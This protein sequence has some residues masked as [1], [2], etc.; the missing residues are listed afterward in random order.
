MS[1][2][3][4]D[5]NTDA[6]VDFTNKLEK[7]HKSAMPVAIRTALNS[8][9][10]DVKQNTMP[11]EAKSNFVNRS[12]NFFKANSKVEQA[13]GF[14]VNTMK[15]TVGFVD[16]NLVGK[17]NYAVK[18]LEQQEQG[19]KIS[20]KAFIPTKNA[21]GGYANKM[22]KAMNRLSSIKNIV[23]A[24]RAKGVNK[25]QRFIKSAVHAGK[26]G[27][28]LAEKN[29]NMILWRVNSL[30][31]TSKGAFKLTALYSYKKK[32]GVKVSK[33]QFMRTASLESGGKIDQYFRDSA[34]KQF[35]KL[36]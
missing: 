5:I 3:V 14:N 8:A 20:N 31:R 1:A 33:T 34:Q 12:K 29:G 17:S 10:F 32:R 30:K 13:Q 24:K 26:G 27:Y 35:D 9:A 16:K 2:I 6:V 25:G 28:V 11:R 15:A 22:V 19:G 4:L 23:D 7:M 18:D 36:R 21:R